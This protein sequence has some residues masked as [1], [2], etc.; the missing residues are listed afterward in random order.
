MPIE[1]GY[2]LETISDYESSD[3]QTIMQEIGILRLMRVIIY[4]L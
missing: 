1:R 2:L 3:F 4:C